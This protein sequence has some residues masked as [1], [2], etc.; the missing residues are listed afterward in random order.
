[1]SQ[2]RGTALVTGASR[3]IGAVYAERLA[4]RGYD[5]IVVARDGVR[6]EELVTIPSLHD[7]DAWLRF[8]ADRR[9][10]STLFGLPRRHRAIKSL[11]IRRRNR[12]ASMVLGFR[13]AMSACR[14]QK[15]SKESHDR[16]NSNPCF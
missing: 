1:M 8:E 2:A 6:L 9:P 4:T 13:L 14:H 11:F 10:L 5:L 7:G 15:D 3:G 12:E 16:Q